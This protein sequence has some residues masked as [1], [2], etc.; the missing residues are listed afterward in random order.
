MTEKQTDKELSEQVCI[1][2]DKVCVLVV[3]DDPAFLELVEN[4]L[5]MHKIFDVVTVSALSDA[6]AIFKPCVFNIALI[7]LVI[8]GGTEETKEFIK[9]LRTSDN[10]LVIVICTG[11][12]E[13]CQD[14]ELLRYV[15]SFI[16]K[17]FTLNE[18]GRKM[19]DLVI[20]YQQKKNNEIRVQRSFQQIEQH[21]INLKDIVTKIQR[22][23]ESNIRNGQCMA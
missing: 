15:D 7:D 16:E 4:V 22:A 13:C 17:P 3:D 2:T 11:Y 1:T 19:L 14:L 8:G 21:L 23:I 18:F 5:L 20:F 9:Y 10:K 12:F 6:R